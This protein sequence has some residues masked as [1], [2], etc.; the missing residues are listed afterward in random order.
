MWRVLPEHIISSN[1]RISMDLS[2]S[3]DQRWES[4]FRYIEDGSVVPVVGRDLLWTDV[5]GQQ[6]NIARLLANQLAERLRVASPANLE[7]DPVDAVVRAYYLMSDHDHERPYAELSDLVNGLNTSPIPPALVKLSAIPFQRFISTTCDDFL[8]QAIESVKA[9]GESVS[10]VVNSLGSAGDI[11]R[12]ERSGERVVVQL[13]G[14]ANPTTDYAITEADVLEFVHQFQRTNQPEHLLNTI[15]RQHLLFVGSGFSGWL[16]R[17]FL[18]LARADRLWINK[19]LRHFFAD[20]AVIR[21]SR[22][23]SFLEHPLTAAAVFQTDDAVQFVDELHRRWHDRGGLRRHKR[24][25]R[26]ADGSQTIADGRVFLSY[27]SEDLPAARR[28]NEL[29]RAAGIDAWFDKTGF[30]P[31]DDWDRIIRTR[32]EQCFL[33]VPLLSRHTHAPEGYF[34]QEWRWA[35][36]RA[37]TIGYGLKFAF[38]I[39]VDDSEVNPTRLPDLFNRAQ[40]TV[41]RGGELSHDFIAALRGAYRA[42]QT[43]PHD[44]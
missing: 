34:N 40:R 26:P 22:L 10:I 36:D 1:R 32:I 35:E 38:P 28:V 18:R 16:V 19:G 3:T 24:A 25:A 44:R 41:A 33:F 31:G 42:F 20:R 4:L 6:I 30:T 37:R 27:A 12:V 17:F 8:P 39:V 9:V 11:P 23:R 2:A 7:D 13:L 21:D 14:R 43:Q 15:R 5:G 29:L